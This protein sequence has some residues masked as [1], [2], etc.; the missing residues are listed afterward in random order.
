MQMNFQKQRGDLLIESLIGTVLMAIIGMGVVLVTS[1]MSISQRDMRIQEIVV[2]QLRAYLINNGN[3]TI[4]LCGG[5]KPAIHVP[6]IQIPEDKIQVHGCGTSV[7][8]TVNN[9]T[10]A[11]VPSPLLISVDDAALGGKIVVGGSGG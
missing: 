5:A 4:N 3:G 1:K 2:N 9:M 6:G 8:A 10:I 11:N 7:T